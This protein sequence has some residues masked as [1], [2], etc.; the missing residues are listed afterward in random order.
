MIKGFTE[1]QN[2][3]SVTE[4]VEQVIEKSGYRAML[5]NEKSIEAES[6]L[7]NIEEFLSVTKAFEERSED[8]SLIA[9]LTDLALIADIDALDKEDASKGNIIL[10]TMHAAKGFNNSL[11][12]SLL[13][14]KKIFSLTLVL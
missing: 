11:S 2:Y 10:M 6:R 13:A 12:F 4:I 9:F 7:E 8:K 14:W 5:Q 3:L 1:M